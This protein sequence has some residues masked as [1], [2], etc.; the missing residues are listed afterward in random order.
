[1]SLFARLF[2]GLNRK[3]E[4]K[5]R[6]W[7]D[8]PHEWT[9]DEA[10]AMA[11]QLLATISRTPIAE[12]LVVERDG[13]RTVVQSRDKLRRLTK[14]REVLVVIANERHQSRTFTK[15]QQ[16]KFDTVVPAITNLL[17]RAK[18]DFNVFLHHFQR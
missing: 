1:M 18:D 9:F 6:P 14:L 15:D 12:D 17:K 16:D 10:L 8:L 7:P 13:V 3:P 2:G 5:I 4:P 11:A